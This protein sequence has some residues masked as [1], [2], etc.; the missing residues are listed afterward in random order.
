MSR[1][2]LVLAVLLTL[3]LA[4]PAATAERP[5]DGRCDS[6]GRLVCAAANVGS[7][8]ACTIASDH[9]AS[10][11]WTA[12]HLWEGFSPLGVPGEASMETRLVLTMCVDGGLCGSSH[13]EE[14]G[15]CAWIG[16][17]TCGGSASYGDAIPPTT[18][19]LGQCLRVTVAQT[20]TVDARIMTG[21]PTLASAT[22]TDASESAG[23]VCAVDD[24]RG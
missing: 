8:V 13:I 12:G 23:A 1:I 15:G 16:P 14:P 4:L 22:W 24:G 5:T 7:Q 19:A 17:V 3:P 18:L 10:C 2:A 11:T 6:T 21:G 9:V 20:I